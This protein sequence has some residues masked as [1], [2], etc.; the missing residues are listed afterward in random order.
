MRKK[1]RGKAERRKERGS[2]PV[3]SLTR[4]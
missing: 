2:I 4:H 3:L 1:K